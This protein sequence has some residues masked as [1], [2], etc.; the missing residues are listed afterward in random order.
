MDSVKEVAFQLGA[1]V[2]ERF[3]CCAVE[4]AATDGRSLPLG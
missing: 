2:T 3:F 4:F 1:Q